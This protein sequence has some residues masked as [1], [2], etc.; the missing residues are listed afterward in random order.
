MCGIA[1]L[2]TTKP[3]PPELIRHM[4]AQLAHRG[5]DGEGSKHFCNNRLAFGHRRLAILDLSPAAAQ[6]MATL[7]GRL[8]L[9][10]NGEIYNNDELRHELAQTG[11]QFRTR[12][13]SEVVLAAYATWGES[14]LDRFQGMWAFLIYDTDQQMLFAS[15]DRFGVKPL[16]YWQAVDGLLAFA[17]EI[18]A[19]TVLPGWRPAM[20]RQRVYD[21]LA[22]GLTEHTSDTLFSG[23]Q[24]LRGGEALRLDLAS[25]SSA[26]FV[27]K[28][29][30]WRWYEP[31]QLEDDSILLVEAAGKTSKLLSEA[32]GSHLR[33]DV[34]VG[35][36]LSGGLD[37]SSIVCLMQQQ[38]TAI[39]EQANQSVFSAC[40]VERSLD[41]R[42]YMAAVVRKT[43]VHWQQVEPQASTLLE[44]LPELVWHQDEPFATTSPYAQW[45][46]FRLA[47][48]HGVKVMLDG[49]GADEVLAG[50]HGFF[51][52]LL[53][54]LAARGRM[55]SLVKEVRA[56]HRYHGYPVQQLLMRLADQMLPAEVRNGLRRLAGR[57]HTHPLWLNLD[58]LGADPVD[59]FEAAG[60]R[61][62]SVQALSMAQIGATNLPML[63]H[64]EDRSSMAHS[65]EARVPFLDHRLV[66]YLLTL[67]D[68]CKI[69]H[70][71][72]KLV[73]REAMRGVLPE[74]VRLRQDKLGFV[75][76][77]AVWVRG[78]AAD[79]R[80]LLAQ[81]I[82]ASQGILQPSLL[83]MF[84]RM[85]SGAIS[86][87]SVVWRAIV[88]GAW[89]ARFAIS[90]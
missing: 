41:E 62:A 30:V 42:P 24:Q 10:Y 23:V 12:S 44:K 85:V 26:G 32:V 38:L 70:G 15:R 77:E 39:G 35:S 61:V 88:F 76:P 59:P 72:T 58:V 25:V 20:H 46:V 78:A 63:L 18:K 54:S 84:D 86:Y 50:Y 80:K 37:S 51:G 16:Y 5:P 19:F 48:D 60:G 22:W 65:V 31:R 7:D 75:T 4:T 52:P 73:L 33:A 57:P 83:V 89:Q 74:E 9:T 79:F 1:C 45:E 87:D 53:A 34:P 29:E 90:L 14:C 36:C 66:E 2:I 56:M 49:Q 47:A 69:H 71:M 40:T 6:P 28:H 21:F 67:P 27:P 82:T 11:Y 64:W 8:W 43:G 81:S 55:F 68:R 13:D 17:S 3:Q